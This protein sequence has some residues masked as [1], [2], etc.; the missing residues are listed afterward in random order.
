MVVI[1]CIR[2]FVKTINR[3]KQKV[4]NLIERKLNQKN[5]TQRS[6]SGL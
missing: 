6:Y 3:L 2:V 5:E 4:K 1:L